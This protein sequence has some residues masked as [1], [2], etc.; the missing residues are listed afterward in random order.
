MQ[1]LSDDYRHVEIR[2]VDDR[3]EHAEDC[4]REERRNCD[5]EK[6]I[7]EFAVGGRNAIE[8]ELENQSNA[9]PHRVMIDVKLRCLNVSSEDAEYEKNEN[10]ELENSVRQDSRVG[11]VSVVN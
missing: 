10:G 11:V 4:F 7:V 3:W 6:H 2:S 1:D 8:R 9:L 5:E